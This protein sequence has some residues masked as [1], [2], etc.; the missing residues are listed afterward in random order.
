MRK[1]YDMLPIVVVIA[2]ISAILFP[3]MSR[4]R[5]KI[6]AWSSQPEQKQDLSNASNK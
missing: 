4:L 2:L 5:A 1:Q 6:D 3:I